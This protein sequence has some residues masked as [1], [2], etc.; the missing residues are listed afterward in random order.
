MSPELEWNLQPGIILALLSYLAIYVWR[1]RWARAEASPRVASGWRL[2]SF[3]TGV[4]MLFAALI[5]PIDGLGEQLFVF[6]MAQH[7]L[8]GDLAA[9]FLILGLTK[10]ILRPVTAR[11]QRVERAVGPLSHPAFAIALYVA[12]LWIWHV[13]AMYQLGLRHPWVHAVQHLSFSVAALLFWWH[14]LSP[15]RNRRRLAGMGVTFYV[16]GAKVL[17]GVL[18]SVIT[19]APIFLYDFYA[20]QPDYWGVTPAADQALAGALM[21]IE[22]SIILT[23]AM[24]A[25]F[26]RM[27][28]ESDRENERE[29][30]YGA[31][32]GDTRA[33]L[34]PTGNGR[35]S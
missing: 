7:I 22:E 10:V 27:L 13:P 6:H 29:E 16:A 1:W 3:A 28:G 12:V 9:V 24:V 35:M 8:L 15:L 2:A 30:R 5:S 31:E 25:L 34:S 19:F 20:A 21:M 14:L 23:V 32:S 4:S 26:V 18:A 33:A 17:T 11:L